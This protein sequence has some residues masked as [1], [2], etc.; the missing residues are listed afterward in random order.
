MGED[1]LLQRV[2]ETNARFLTLGVESFEAYG[3]T[4]VRNRETPHRH[5]VN[6]VALIRTSTIDDIEALFRQVEVEYVGQQHRA[7]SIDALTPP[8]FT[9]RLA[10]EDG[11]KHG[12]V[13]V[14]ALEGQLGATPRDVE[15]REVLSDDDWDA[16][17][18]LDA[19]W[20]QE[21]SV[22]ALGP[23]KPSL[24]DEFMVARKLKAPAA[25]AWFACVDGVP[26]AFFSSWPG[27]NGVGIVEDLYCHPEY[28]KQGL[29]TALIARCVSDCRERGAGPII[30][31]SNIDDTP[32]H[33]Y[34]RMGFR[35]LF[36][37][38][39]YTKLLEDFPGA[40]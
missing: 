14:H 39:S 29:A 30:I 16:Y 11:Y 6:G 17:R 19:M 18:E 31:N 24:H 13:L 28:R 36:V 22:G 9:G 20:W 10:L 38:R 27:D 2:C 34:A 23:Y 3:A 40:P 32:K 8:L 21:S 4:F 26:R 7:Y 37:A 33:I 35:P 12:E 1:E 5:D 15:I 25:R